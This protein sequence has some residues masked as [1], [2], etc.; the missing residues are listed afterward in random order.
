[1]LKGDPNKVFS[2]LFEAFYDASK[3]AYSEKR[4][5]DYTSTLF[6]KV[7]AILNDISA[8]MAASVLAANGMVKND[9]DHGLVYGKLSNSKTFEVL[10]VQFYQCLIEKMKC[11]EFSAKRKLKIFKK[12]VQIRLASVTRKWKEGTNVSKDKRNVTRK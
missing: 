10:E 7:D 6:A 3:D 11:T 12:C 5:I 9:S 8:Q 4:N 1:M 2:D